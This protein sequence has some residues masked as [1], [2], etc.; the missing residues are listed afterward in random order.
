M[1]I[2]IQSIHLN[3]YYTKKEEINQDFIPIES[4]IL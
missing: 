2:I 3:S 1:S 4:K